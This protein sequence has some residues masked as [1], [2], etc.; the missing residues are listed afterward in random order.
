M[1]FRSMEFYLK[2]ENEA[3]QSIKI[4]K[5]KYEKY[6]KKLEML[7]EHYISELL[8]RD[9]YQETKNAYLKEQKEAHDTLEKVQ[10]HWQG[11]LEQQH[12]KMEWAEELIKCQK[13]TE[14]TKGI[15]ERFIEKI[16]VESGSEITVC[17]WFGDIFEEEVLDLSGLERGI[18]DAV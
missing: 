10:N 9:E 4:A 6:G 16:V 3:E 5:T 1:L 8:D 12:A 7:F 17:F 14:I 11:I 15:V 2:L 18:L 13:I